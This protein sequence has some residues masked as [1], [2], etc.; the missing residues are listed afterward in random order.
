MLLYQDII[1]D[2]NPILRNKSEDV[3]LPLSDE[4][5]ATIEKINEYLVNGYDKEKV[6]KFG[7]RPAY[8]LAA[9]QIGVFKKIFVILAT[10]ETGKTH[11]YGAINPKII[12]HSEE[13]VYL[14]G[15]EGCLS[16]DRNVDGFV[17]RHKRVKAKVWLYDFIEK[18]VREEILKL[19][20]LMAIIFQ[21]EYDHLFGILF[22]DHIDKNNP[23]F[24][25]NNSTGLT[26]ITN[27]EE[28]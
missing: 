18:T 6:E 25:Q 22:Y 17:H 28:K 19:E 7:I 21:H 20:N 3:T 14:P 9:P 2:D 1:K 4:D 13:K 23:F 5:I 11:H 27:D 8:G 15:G 16:V 26:F 12:S 10:D 24:I